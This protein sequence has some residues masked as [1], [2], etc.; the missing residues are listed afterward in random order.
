MAAIL[1]G[2]ISTVADTSELQRR[3][4]NGA[5]EDHG[6]DWNW[7]QDDYREM[8]GANGGADR[9]DEYAKA[10]GDEV[11][12]AAVHATKSEIFQRL[13]AD[14]GLAP[15]P[16]VADVIDAAKAKGVKLGFVTT[17]SRANITALL[18][19]LEPHLG[20]DPFDLIVDSDA[21]DTPKPDAACYL[22]A[23]EQLGEDAA[24][25]VA[26]E[27]NA[28]GVK[29][30]TAAGVTCIAFPNENTEG[31]DFGSA[32]ETVNNLDQRRVVS[33]AVSEGF[34]E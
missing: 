26:I 3:A 4:F 19:A 1:F 25:S 29:A 27:D 30:A 7:S 31:A 20:A 5:F 12:A 16:G 18:S 14:S 32:A 17:T 33:L 21:V 10:V 24:K 6:L 28:G 8:L 2:S 15:R 9:I 13:V 34:T 11:D 23:L 22:W